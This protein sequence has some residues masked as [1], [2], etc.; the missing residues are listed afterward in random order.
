MKHPSCKTSSRIKAEEY[1]LPLAVSQILF[2]L[3]EDSYPICPRCGVTLEREYQ[4]FC[5]RCGQCLDWN[6]YPRG[7]AIVK[8]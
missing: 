5:D 1:R 4:S 6:G 8:Y 2:S 7:A 3:N